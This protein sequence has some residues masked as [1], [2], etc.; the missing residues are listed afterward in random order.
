MGLQ[1]RAGENPQER[2]YGPVIYRE[3][4][5]IRRT[6]QERVTGI[7]FGTETLPG[8]AEKKGITSSS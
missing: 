8:T 2:R 5:R 1:E 7:G 4:C 3:S 6:P